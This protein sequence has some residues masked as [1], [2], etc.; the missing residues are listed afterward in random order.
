MQGSTVV[1]NPPDGN[2]CAYLE[3]LE[4]LLA[5]ELDWLAPG[6][7]FLIDQPHSVVRKTIAHRLA[8]EAKVLAA[9]DGAGPER[10]LPE[11]ELLA[12]VYA[13]TPTKLHAMA[14]RSL[15]AHLD[16]LVEEG[17]V[18]QRDGQWQQLAA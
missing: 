7:G 2:M 1:I 10:S 14:L 15:R 6:H 5:I 16:K 4:D 17:K 3:A 8:R 12:R 13:D 11:P 9:L 18:A